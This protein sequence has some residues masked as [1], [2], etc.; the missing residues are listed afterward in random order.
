MFLAPQ[1]FGGSAPPNFWSGIIKL[2]QI[3]TKWQSFRA[4]GRGSSENA[5]RK[6]NLRQNISP[7]GTVVPGGLMNISAVLNT[8]SVVSTISSLLVAVA[9]NL[10]NIAATRCTTAHSSQRD[11][12]A[13]WHFVA[14]VR[15][16]RLR[17]LMDARLQSSTDELTC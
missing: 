7:S 10:H 9:T 15:N 4:I 12:I 11:N 17:R 8:K 1:F 16:T 5:W 2:G 6:K 13:C 3:P 14:G